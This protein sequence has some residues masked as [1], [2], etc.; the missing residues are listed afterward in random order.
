L[1][2]LVVYGAFPCFHNKLRVGSDMNHPVIQAIRGPLDYMVDVDGRVE[3]I[4]VRLG[5]AGVRLELEKDGF[6]PSYTSIGLLTETFGNCILD[7]VT[8]VSAI[9]CAQADP[10]TG[11]IFRSA[12]LCD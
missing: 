6:A 2:K 11:T 10:R 8:Q 12:P 1:I 7:R 4:L 5:Q 3:Q 9:P